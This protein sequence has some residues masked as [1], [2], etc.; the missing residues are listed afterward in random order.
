[1]DQR[2]SSDFKMA[3]KLAEGLTDPPIEAREAVEVGS[4]RAYTGRNP[5]LRALLSFEVQIPQ[6]GSGDVLRP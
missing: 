6:E 2:D 5:M 3:S 4:G 1:M